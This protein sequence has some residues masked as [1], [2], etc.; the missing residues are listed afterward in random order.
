MNRL[1]YCPNCGS[2]CPEG[3]DVSSHPAFPAFAIWCPDCHL[4]GPPKSSYPEAEWAWNILPRR[5]DAC[6]KCRSIEKLEAE[7]ALVQARLTS[8]QAEC[9]GLRA[10]LYGRQSLPWWKKLFG[11]AR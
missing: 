4:Q 3:R 8:S 9:L 7:R 11:R 2:P 10:S 5:G 1:L 6:E